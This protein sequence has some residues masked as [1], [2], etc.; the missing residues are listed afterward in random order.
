TYDYVKLCFM[1]HFPSRPLACLLVVFLFSIFS[2]YATKIT[3]S[4]R[5]PL[6][7]QKILSYR[8][9]PQDT[10]EGKEAKYLN[11]LA[12]DCSGWGY[13][14]EDMDLTVEKIEETYPAVER[15]RI[16]WA[17][18]QKICLTNFLMAVKKINLAKSKVLLRKYLE[19]YQDQYFP[20]ARLSEVVLLTEILSKDCEVQD[21]TLFQQIM[22][23]WRTQENNP[24]WQKSVQEDFSKNC[25]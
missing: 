8:Y 10:P 11:N 16:I 17:Q 18:F 6:E 9:N 5:S 15:E 20:Y 23:R 21:K 25:R 3:V 13:A 14:S 24:S 7:R 12:R 22:A 4:P 1:R 2:A 19:N